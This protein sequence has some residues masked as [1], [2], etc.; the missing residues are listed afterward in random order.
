M[1][2][3]VM[4][5]AMLVIALSGIVLASFAFGEEVAPFNASALVK[6]GDT[7]SYGSY[8]IIKIGDSIYQLKDPG[9][10]KAKA[11]GLVGVDMYVICGHAKALLIDLGNNYIDGY[12]GDEIPPR[13][14][15]AQELRAV[16]G[17]LIGKLPLEIAV[18]HAHPDHDGM[19][20]AFLD[21][22]TIIWMPRG[23]DL[24][25]PQKEHKIDP[26][27]YA[28]FD[29]EAKTFDLGGGRVV[30]PLL[31]R[32][33]SNGGTVYLLAK[34]MM[35]FTG[36][37]IGLGA[38]RSIGTAAA[39]KTFAEDTQKL[40][41]Y[42]KSNFSP[43]E[44]YALKVYVGHS[45]GNTIAGFRSPNHGPVD[46][47]YLDWRF[48]QDMASCA[49]AIVKGQWLVADSGLRL[50]EMKDPRTGRTTANMLYGIGAVQI[51]IEAAYE[52]AG[53][54]MPQ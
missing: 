47:D 8:K 22:K 35:L 36:D 6:L 16:I 46:V 42:I 51:P 38:G 29:H 54:K 14:N 4:P 33:H 5:R 53:M 25:R 7:V 10:P 37:C 24:S 52:A 50:M 15:A 43:Y 34:D 31:V 48:V 41:D 27:V 17:G 40:V 18:T 30:K 13:K 45:A 39:L 49:N 26:A 28:T 1:E 23:E 20:G 11:G 32:G 3:N 19:T 2:R 9:D 21:K 12:V 44:R